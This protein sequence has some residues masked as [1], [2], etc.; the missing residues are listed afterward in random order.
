VA[1]DRRGVLDGDRHAVEHAELLPAGDRLS[2]RRR[3]FPRLVF[4][5]VGEAVEVGL[6][7]VGAVE[8]CGHGLHR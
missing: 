7:C 5:H 2:S 3:R 4:P 1:G 8:R 6:D